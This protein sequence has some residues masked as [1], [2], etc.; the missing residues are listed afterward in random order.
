METK[1]GGESS[2]S[3]SPSLGNINPNG[4][5]IV[6]LLNGRNYNEWSYSAELALGGT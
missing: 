1:Q 5:L 3:G 6:D 2:S 4:I